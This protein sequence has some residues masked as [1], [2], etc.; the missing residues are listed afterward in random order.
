ETMTRAIATARAPPRNRIRRAYRRLSQFWGC[1]E[2][3]NKYKLPRL[4][5]EN[6]HVWVVVEAAG[7]RRRGGSRPFV[8]RRSAVGRRGARS[9]QS[10]NRAAAG[11][12]R[13]IPHNPRR[14]SRTP[15]AAYAAQLS[16]LALPAVRLRRLP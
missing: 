4:S 3:T 5:K 6:L 8:N 12:V 9:T 11:D 10:G 7:E 13:R 1:A 2:W 16:R 14:G 15:R